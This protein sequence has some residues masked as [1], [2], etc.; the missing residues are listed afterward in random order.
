VTLILRN[1]SDEEHGIAVAG[2][3]IEPKE[4]KGIGKGETVSITVD[5]LAG[6][7][8]F[9]CP[10]DEHRID[11]SDQETGILNVG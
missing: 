10:V 6:E 7:Y 9:Y 2:T 11:R 1:L 3:D 8:E 4:S 5:L